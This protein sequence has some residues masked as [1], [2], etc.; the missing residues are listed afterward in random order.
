M[1]ILSVTLAMAGGCSEYGLSRG[2]KDVNAPDE[3]Q[4]LDTGSGGEGDTEITSCDEIELSDE[5]GG[6]ETCLHEPV[7]GTLA[8][9][10]EWSIEVFT[11][12][13]E[14]DEVLMT[15]VVGQ[16][17]DDDGD[18]FIT[19]A[20]TPDIAIVTDDGGDDQDGT[21][22]VLRVLSGDGSGQW[23]E[24]FKGEF[25]SIECFPYRYSNLALGDV[26]ADGEPEIV[27]TIEMVPEGEG[28][29]GEAPEDVDPVG[30]PPPTADEDE[31][32][33]YVAAVSLAGEVEWVAQDFVLD[34][35]GHA[36]ALADLDGDGTV[37]VVI[38]PVILA[39]EDGSLLAEGSAGSGR[40][41]AYEE[42]GY[43]TIVADLDGDGTQEVVAGNTVYD[44]SGAVVC[45]LAVDDSDGFPA[46]ADLDGDGLGDFVWVGDGIVRVADAACDLQ[47]SW[48][49][50]GDGNGGPPTISDFDGDGEPEIGMASGSS[51][52]VYETDGTVLW[53]VEITD[54][55]SHATGSAVYDFEGDGRPEVL[56]SDEV[57]LW[58]FDGATG[59]ARLED[60]THTSRTLHEYPTVADVDGDG[61][62]EI[63]VPNGGGHYGT[64][65]TGLYVLGNT[66]DSWLA[67]RQV[68]NQHAYCI[69]NI[70]DD[71]TVPSAP[72]SN[73]PF[74]NS[75]RSGDLNPV[76]AGA[77]ADAVPL[78]ESC[79]LECEDG[80][81]RVM[82]RV[83]NQGAAPLRPGI[84]VTLYA[85]DGDTRTALET[86]W[87]DLMLEPGEVSADL[88]FEV[89]VEDGGADGLVLLVDDAEGL[90]YV[91]ECHEDNNE[92]VFEDAVCD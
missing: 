92:A 42:I 60:T 28:E 48:S 36:P 86:Q 56:Y 58:I 78:A 47:A 41:Y 12:Y 55:S 81:L 52:A 30:P 16:L 85:V 9:E 3:E 39:G 29:G 13:P 32:P 83:G 43:H 67:G 1:T 72:G 35:G 74:Y 46:V 31:L 19:S 45:E 33:C 91:R 90:T 23:L 79:T 26:D 21:H 61:L 57:T 75:F 49:L 22:G 17:S 6:D 65:K 50:E 44:S 34:C 68:W 8:V 11:S 53:S 5:V 64:E 24:V 70:E 7:T 80:V 51:Y 15:P 4:S 37:E 88:S 62:P 71:L 76:Y 69:T 63:V 18:G 73:W 14:Y 59:E 10:V 2:G 27:L 20:D 87:T 66:D 54:D 38:G 89:A 25:G 84:P 82:A 40:Y 77:S